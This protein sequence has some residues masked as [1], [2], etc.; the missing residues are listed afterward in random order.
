MKPVT[1]VENLSPALLEKRN[2]FLYPLVEG[3]SK[4]VSRNLINGTLACSAGFWIKKNNEDFILTAGHCFEIVQHYLMDIKNKYKT[5]IKANHMTIRWVILRLVQF[6]VVGS[7]EITNCRV[8]MCKTGQRTG[9]SCSF[10]TAFNSIRDFDTIVVIPMENNAGGS[11]G[12]MFQYNGLNGQSH[13][14][15]AVSIYIGRN[16][17]QQAIATEY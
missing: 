3:G 10:V 12:S 5:R 15:D 16:F 4:I 2:N 1:I 14:A 6:Q 13:L 11:G 9:I 8:H 17:T 7:S